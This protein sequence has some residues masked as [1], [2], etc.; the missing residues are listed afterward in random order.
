[1]NVEIKYREM[2]ASPALTARAQA[3]AEKLAALHPR[4]QRCEVSIENANRS[5]HHGP[6]FRV[7]IHLDVPG[8]DIEVSRDQGEYEDAHAAI[9]DAFRT[10]KRRLVEHAQTLRGD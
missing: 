5:H 4:L 9:A 2:T 3:G 1:M 8:Q 10:A 6:R 7:R